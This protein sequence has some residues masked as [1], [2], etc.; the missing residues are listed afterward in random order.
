MVAPVSGRTV[1]GSWSI[2][3]HRSSSSSVLRIRTSCPNIFTGAAGEVSFAQ[4]VNG[5]DEFWS[6][7]GK[8]DALAGVLTACE[9]ERRGLLGNARRA[10]CG[11]QLWVPVVDSESV[12][13]R[14][15]EAGSI[16]VGLQDDFRRSWCNSEN[17]GPR[18]SFSPNTSSSIVK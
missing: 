14:V 18:S 5:S 6:W 11:S 2:S 10:G 13:T 9:R 1:N 8:R 12:A 16:S 17:C 4:R 15:G 7:E 3:V